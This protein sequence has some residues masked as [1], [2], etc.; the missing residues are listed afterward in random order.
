MV[1]IVSRWGGGKPTT[2]YLHAGRR[3]MLINFQLVSWHD[4]NCSTT[5]CPGFM[6]APVDNGRPHCGQLHNHASS[7]QIYDCMQTKVDNELKLCMHVLVATLSY[8]RSVGRTNEYCASHL[9]GICSLHNAAWYDN[10]YWV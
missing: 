10:S 8:T 4:Q 7:M 5:N 2:F 1:S 9:K 3:K 6:E